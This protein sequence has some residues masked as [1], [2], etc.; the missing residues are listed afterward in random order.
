MVF[1]RFSISSLR[2]FISKPISEITSAGGSITCCDLSDEASAGSD[3]KAENIG[4]VKECKG[5]VEAVTINGDVSCG[6][7]NSE[8]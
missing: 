8:Q 5:N 6:G 7:R 2:L 4:S 3:I 1:L